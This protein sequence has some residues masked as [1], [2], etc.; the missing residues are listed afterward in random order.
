MFSD[1]LFL[2]KPKKNKNKNKKDPVHHMG[3]KKTKPQDDKK[4]KL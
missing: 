1:L 3:E 4:G 2:S